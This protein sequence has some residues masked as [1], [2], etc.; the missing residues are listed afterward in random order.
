MISR[1][2]LLI[3]MVSLLPGLF[4]FPPSRAAAADDVIPLVNRDYFQVVR[5]VIT[6]AKESILCVMYMSQLSV[7]HPFGGESLLLRDLIAAK[8]RGVDVRVILEDK[9][10]ANNKYAYNFLKSAGV[11]VVYDTDNIT[12]H[13]KLLVIDDEITIIGSHNWTFSG[14]RTNNEASVLIKSKEV[15][16][17]MR[18]AVENIAVKEEQEAE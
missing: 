6:G 8:N 5:N 17:A 14:L 18:N 13:N 10:D 1:G 7:N 3:M 12:T 4:L 2:F 15:A 11:N 16:K 9:P